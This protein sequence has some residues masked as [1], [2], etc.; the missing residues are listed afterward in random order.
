MGDAGLIQEFEV[1]SA[2]VLKMSDGLA[3][4]TEVAFSWVIELID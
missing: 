1:V 4:G 3:F 2:W